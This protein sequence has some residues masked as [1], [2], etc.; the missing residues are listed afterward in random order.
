[1]FRRFARDHMA[2]DTEEAAKR[3]AEAAVDREVG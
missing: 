2:K 1:M 3:I